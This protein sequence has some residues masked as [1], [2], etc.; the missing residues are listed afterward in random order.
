MDFVLLQRRIHSLLEADRAAKSSIETGIPAARPALPSYHARHPPA[1]PI[2]PRHTG[3]ADTRI[4]R[5]P[6][7]IS[8]SPARQIQNSRQQQ[9]YQN[10]IINHA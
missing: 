8:Q 1:I 3:P 4:Q 5:F 6:S 10:F 2:H 7:P 9:A